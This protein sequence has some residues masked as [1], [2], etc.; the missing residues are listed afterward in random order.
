M[1]HQAL[2]KCFQAKVLNLLSFLTARSHVQS[3][4]VVGLARAT[5]EEAEQSG[6]GPVASSSA[7]MTL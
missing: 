2:Q 1:T 5:V 3:G 6:S 7:I 4:E